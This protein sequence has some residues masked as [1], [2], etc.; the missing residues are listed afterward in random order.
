MRPKRRIAL[1][2]SLLG[3][4]V[5]VVAVIPSA[6]GA[7]AQHRG[8]IATIACKR[9]APGVCDESGTE[10]LPANGSGSQETDTV[11]GSSTGESTSLQPFNQQ[12]LADFDEMWSSI[13]DGYPKFAGVQNTTVRRLLTCAIFARVHSNIVASFTSTTLP[14][15]HITADNLDAALLSTCIQVTIT[16]QHAPGQPATRPP[17]GAARRRPS[18]PP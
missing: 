14:T 11:P 18:R 17:R 10:S 6:L 1:V 2:V 13:V 16:G 7:A 4:L 9:I 5:P 15:A 12:E 8:P 3:A